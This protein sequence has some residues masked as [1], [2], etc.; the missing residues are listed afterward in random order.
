MLCAKFAHQSGTR[1]KLQKKD[2][3]GV[4]LVLAAMMVVVILMLVAFSVDLGIVAS[5][6]TDMKRA[7]DSAALAGAGRLIDGADAANLQAFEF[8]VHNPVGNYNLAAEDENWKHNLEALLAAHVDEFETQLGHWDAETRT[9]AVSDNLPSTIRVVASRPNLPLFFS[10]IFGYT[11]FNVSA[12]SIAQY[13]PRDIAIVLDFSASMNDDSELKRIGEN[14]NNRTE[15]ENSLAEIY[16]DLSPMSHGNLQFQTQHVTLVGVP[17]ATNNQPQITVTFR[18]DDVYVTSS[19]E[20]SNVVMQFSDGS[21]EKIED[22]VSPTGEFRGSGDNYGK[23]ITKVWVKSGPNDSGEGPGYGEA[24]ED[25]NATVITALGLTDVTYP[26]PSGSWDE[27]ITYVKTNYNVTRAG[28]RRSYGY[29]TLIN[30][31][32]EVKPTHAQ[33]PD[34]WKTRAQPI[35]AVKDAVGVF[36]DYIQQVD[37]NDRVA[38]ILYNSSSQEALVEHSLSEDFDTIETTISQRQAGHYDRYTNIG[39][40]IRYARQE[41]VDNARPGAFKMIVLMTDGMANRPYG[42]DARQYALDQADLAKLAGYPIATISLGSGADMTLMQSI[43]DRTDGH[44]FNI[45]GM[46]TVSDYQDDLRDVFS[47]IAKERPLVLVK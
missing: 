22:L 37:S 14:G 34:L 42:I 41:L 38:L 39:D 20:L 16:D 12:E 35:K 11:Q 1:G 24:F 46:S 3:Q 43:A 21:T 26:Y 9:F 23:Y 4:I 17:P 29:K 8:L 28:Y 31:W 2:R 18:S 6:N 13:Q 33:T 40:G 19:K 5:A 47:R 10:G 45:P 15:V 27:Y 25:D 32:L 36:M 30:Y 44:H 7:T